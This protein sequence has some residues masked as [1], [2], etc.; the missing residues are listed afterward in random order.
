[1]AKPIVIGGKEFPRVV[2]YK[3]S[4]LR[5]LYFLIAVLWL[6]SASGGFDGTVSFERGQWAGQSLMQNLDDEWPTNLIVLGELFSL[7]ISGNSWFDERHCSGR[8]LSHQPRPTIHGR[9]VGPQTHPHLGR[10]HPIRWNRSTISGNK[11]VCGWIFRLRPRVLTSL[12]G[13]CS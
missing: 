3:H 6:S 4:C 1:M 5:R 8:Q 10:L 13:R 9:L 7:P 11:Y 2:W 12:A